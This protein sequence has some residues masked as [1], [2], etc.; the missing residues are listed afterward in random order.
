M[1]IWAEIRE[2]RAHRKETHILPEVWVNHFEGVYGGG[3]NWVGARPPLQGQE[4]QMLDSVVTKREVREAIRGMKTG[5]AA[6][7]DGIQA[8][9]LQLF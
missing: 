6:G 5:K 9:F 7:L 1:S 4:V 2:I 3:G 8:E